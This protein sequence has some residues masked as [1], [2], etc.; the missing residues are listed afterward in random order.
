[1]STLVYARRIRLSD[2]KHELVTELYRILVVLKAEP[3]GARYRLL[4]AL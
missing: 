4:V 3:L 1:M 2:G